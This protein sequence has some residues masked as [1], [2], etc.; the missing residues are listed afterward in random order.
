M[1]VREKLLAYERQVAQ[2]P[3]LAAG[4]RR[5]PMDLPIVRPERDRILP[6]R[7][8]SREEELRQELERHAREAHDRYRQEQARE[9]GPRAGY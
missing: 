6:L 7:Q 3:P 9:R 5:D 8:R 2:T 1:R 4:R